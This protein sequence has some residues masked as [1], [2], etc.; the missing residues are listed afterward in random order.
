MSL[1]KKPTAETSKYI[2]ECLLELLVLQRLTCNICVIYL[3][4]T[5]SRMFNEVKYFSFFFFKDMRRNIHE[6]GVN[7]MV[8][9]SSFAPPFS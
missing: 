1:K 8:I 3:Y 4:S 9:V 6:A 5:T 7:K 2:L